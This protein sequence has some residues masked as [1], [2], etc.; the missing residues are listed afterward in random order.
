M[1]INEI[2]DLIVN[3]RD[4]KYNSIVCN[5][6][7]DSVDMTEKT[8]DVKTLEGGLITNV[9]LLPS[10]VNGLFIKPSDNS[11]VLVHSISDHDYYVVMFSQF[12]EMDLG[13]GSFGGIAKIQQLTTKLNNLENK[14]NSIIST[15]NTHVHSGVTT[16]A[17]SSAATLT[18]ISGTLTP[19]DQSELENIKVKHGV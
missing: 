4:K 17:G 8:C 2:F 11:L 16:G 6:V 12:D 10:N 13:D 19:T 18:T 1:T 7:S 5:V 15:F 14:V 3:Q 9:R